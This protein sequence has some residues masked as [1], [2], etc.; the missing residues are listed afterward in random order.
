M[1]DERQIDPKFPE[2]TPGA[3]ERAGVRE[4]PVHCHKCASANAP[5]SRY[6]KKCGALLAQRHACSSC[7]A[8]NDSDARFCNNC[9]ARL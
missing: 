9:G 8:V 4:V 1:I 2:I 3:D 7:G 6:C 5:N